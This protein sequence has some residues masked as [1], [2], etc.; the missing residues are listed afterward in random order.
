MLPLS[1]NVACVKNQCGGWGSGIE[2]GQRREWWGPLIPVPC[3][4]VSTSSLLPTTKCSL[5]NFFCCK[6]SCNLLLNS[7]TFPQLLVISQIHLPF[8]FDLFYSGSWLSVSVFLS[9]VPLHIIVTQVLQLLI[10]KM[11]M[12]KIMF[13]LMFQSLDA[14]GAIN[15]SPG[16]SGFKRQSTSLAIQAVSL[17]WNL[18]W[19][20][21]IKLMK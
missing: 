16:N 15:E 21:K 7:L 13:F 18:W 3:T 20:M 10:C 17:L 14:L 4:V 1:L 12:N 11:D 6:V 5:V 9:S 2:I 19:V 8:Y